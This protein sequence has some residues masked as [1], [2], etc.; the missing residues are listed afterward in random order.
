MLEG[1]CVFVG[2]GGGGG[3]ILIVSAF[4]VAIEEVYMSFVS[5][6]Q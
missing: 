1:M 6:Q 4:S 2:G 5:R 3:G